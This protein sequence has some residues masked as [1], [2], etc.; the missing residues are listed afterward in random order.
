MENF[1]SLIMK[2]SVRKATSTLGLERT[3]EVIE[4]ISNPVLRTKLRKAY[5]EQKVREK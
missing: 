1:I 5:Y 4:S 3:L 2:N